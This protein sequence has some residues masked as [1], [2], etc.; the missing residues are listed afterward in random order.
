MKNLSGDWERSPNGVSTHIFRLVFSQERKMV[1]DTFI[2][3]ADRAKQ[4][5]FRQEFGDRGLVKDR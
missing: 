4:L 1:A 5:T 3:F 2:R